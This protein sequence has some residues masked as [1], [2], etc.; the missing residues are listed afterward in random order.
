MKQPNAC[1]SRCPERQGTLPACAPLAVPYVPF[2]QEGSPM[3]SDREALNQGT[4][5]PALNLPFH[6]AVNGAPVPDTPLSQIQALQFVLQELA[7]YLDTHQEDQEAFALFQ[8]YSA[9]LDAARAAY[10]PENAPLTRAAAAAK[11]NWQWTNTPWP[12][13]EKGGN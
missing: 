1:S 12:W 13:E 10:D 11:P 5:Y 4:L 9:L 8:Q 2:Q 3:Y 7:L 6:L